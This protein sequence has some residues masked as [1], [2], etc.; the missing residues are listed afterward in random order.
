[1]EKVETRGTITGLYITITIEKVALH[2]FD[3]NRS[4]DRGTRV[5]VRVPEMYRTFPKTLEERGRR[6]QSVLAGL[7]SGS[8]LSQAKQKDA[9]WVVE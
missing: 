8:S 4:S 9:L 5:A 1:M 7:C 3:P 2:P 6:Q